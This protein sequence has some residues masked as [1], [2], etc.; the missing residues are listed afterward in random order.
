MQN[1]SAK[2]KEIMKRK[3]INPL[4]HMRVTIGV[5]NQNAQASARVSDDNDYTYY[6]NLTRPMDNYS[7]DELYAACD[8]DYTAV[9]GSMYF[10]PRE[11]ADVVLNQGIV[12]GEL[13]GTIEFVFPYAYDIKGLTVDF[14]KAYPVEFTIESDNKSVVVSGNAS[15]SFITEEVFSAAT[16]LRFVP[17]A[18]INGN[19]RFRINQIT[20]GIGIYFDDKSIISATKKE[21]ISP[22]SEELPTI[23]FDMT[24]RNKNRAYD[25]ENEEST[26]NF[27]EIGQK[28]EVLYGQS[29]DDDSIEWMPG[30]C[31]GLKQWSADDDQMKLG[32]TDCFDKM[33]GIYYRGT[34]S[35]EGVSLYDLAVDVLSDAG[36]DSREYW[37]DPY[38]Q[39]VIIHNPMPAIAHKEALQIIANAGRCILYQDRAGKIIMK[40]SFV[41]DMIATSEDEAYFSHVENILDQSEKMA[42]A[43][44][45]KDYTDV[46][47]VQYFLPR[48]ESGMVYLNTGYISGAIADDGGNFAVNPKVLLSLETAF[49]CF[50]MTLEFGANPP[51]SI[52]INSF[53]NEQLMESYEVKELPSTTVINHEFP[54]FDKLEIE[55][56]QGTPNNRVALDNISF[57]DSTDYSLK[58]GIELL[59]TPEGTRLEKVKEVQMNR[60]IYGMSSDDAKELVRENIS[61]SEEE[62]S[63]IFYFSAAS[64][65]LTVSAEGLQEGQS[66]KIVESS[67][68]YALVLFDGVEGNVE[69]V[70]TGKEYAVAQ[71]KVSR[72][73][74]AT[75][76]IESW[77]NPIVSSVTHASD[78]AEW[79]GNYLSSDREYTLSYRGEPRLDANDIAFLEN[80]YVPDLLIRITDHTLKFN[81]GFSGTIQARRDMSYVAAA[82]N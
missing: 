82:K 8:Q 71:A 50:G 77:E 52:L 65:N 33:D 54:E 10:L 31:L 40:S 81:G 47:P 36:I 49:K 28:I 46:T 55:F 53:Y 67:S 9:D 79:I 76:Y 51:R 13:L 1:A 69:V 17:S 3:F 25:V 57:G 35:S 70:I 42:Y 75:G 27:L 56:T 26:I 68:Y 74:N 22:I 14:G 80:K 18:M 4:C 62:N 73:L 60:T 39:N 7:V 45:T 43:L 34:Y 78:V 19:S 29:M 44:T 2:Y 32:A 59:K 72:Q 21:H 5:I 58:Y 20:M 37:V 63:H 30:I 64:Y 6:S 61:V 66:V 11:S 48:Q 23:D 12:S 41:P 38:L 15:G 16:Y 24:V